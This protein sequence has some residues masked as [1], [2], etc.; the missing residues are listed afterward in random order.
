MIHSNSTQIVDTAG[1]TQTGG[2]SVREYQA[3]WRERERDG[4]SDKPEH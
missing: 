1:M 3:F 2:G 4:V